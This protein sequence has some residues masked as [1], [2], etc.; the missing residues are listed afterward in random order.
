MLFDK[1]R[2]LDPKKLKEKTNEFI[3][4]LIKEENERLID[5]DADGRTFAELMSDINKHF[6]DDEKDF[7]ATQYILYASIEYVNEAES[8]I[9]LKNDVMYT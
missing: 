2:K 7:L 4:E 5:E 8:E 3:K 6:S 1:Y 9:D